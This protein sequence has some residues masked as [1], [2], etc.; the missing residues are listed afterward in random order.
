M[1]MLALMLVK[2]TPLYMGI[3]HFPRACNP[4]YQQPFRRVFGSFGGRTFSQVRR[5]SCFWN[6]RW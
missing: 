6:S 3:I 4:M 2:S 5:P 1:Y